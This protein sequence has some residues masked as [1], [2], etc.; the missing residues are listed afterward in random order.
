MTHLRSSS[1][2]LASSTSVTIRDPAPAGVSSSDRST[3]DDRRTMDPRGPGSY[4]NVACDRRVARTRD[5]DFDR[6]RP[7]R[8][9][10]HLDGVFPFAPD[11]AI[12]TAPGPLR[13]SEAALQPLGARAALVQRRQDGIDP[14]APWRRARCRPW[15]GHFRRQQRIRAREHLVADAHLA[16]VGRTRQPQP[17]PVRTIE[18]RPLIAAVVFDAGDDR[19]DLLQRP[20]RRH[21]RCPPTP[22]HL[23]RGLPACAG[24]YPLPAIRSWRRAAGRSFGASLHDAAPDRDVGGEPV[25][26]ILRSGC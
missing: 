15:L 18:P 3:C 9:D 8:I 25:P 22:L 10:Q 26:V 24:Q 14:V 23:H 6:H 19:R 7:R 16:P 11:V 13:Q 2:T 4:P 5:V 12:A 20:R 17:L 21:E 1:C